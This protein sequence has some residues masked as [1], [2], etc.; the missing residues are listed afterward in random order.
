MVVQPGF[1]RPYGVILAEERASSPE[2]LHLAMLRFAA[3]TLKTATANGAEY[4]DEKQQFAALYAALK[5]DEG[6]T[7]TTIEAERLRRASEAM[8]L[9]CNPLRV[10]RGVVQID[11]NTFVADCLG[12]KIDGVTPPETFVPATDK[13]VRIEGFTPAQWEVYKQALAAAERAYRRL[14]ARDESRLGFAF[15]LEWNRRA[16]AGQ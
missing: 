13:D 10:A 15:V 6:R 3:R 8:W 11:L 7:P 14:T 1:Q 16:Q 4:A 12:G 5:L 2:N 9:A